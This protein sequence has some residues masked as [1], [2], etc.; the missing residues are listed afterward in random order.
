MG[1][2][3]A[4]VLAG[5]GGLENVREMEDGNQSL[6]FGYIDVEGSH[7]VLDRM[8]FAQVRPGKEEELVGVRVK[9]GAFY[10]E[11]LTNGSYH[12]SNFVR[13]LGA[14]TYMS[15]LPKSGEGAKTFK[16]EKPGLHF[17]GAYKYT[18][19]KAGFNTYTFELKPIASPT[20]KQILE[21]ILPSTKGTKWEGM[22]LKR[23]QALK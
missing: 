17:V 5:C 3:A 21:Q 18:R 11:N 8:T 6:V 12:I 23:L 1:L 16:I 2:T 22:V 4:L 20:Q 14:N 15:A 9:D 10:V 13:R 7:T 19:I